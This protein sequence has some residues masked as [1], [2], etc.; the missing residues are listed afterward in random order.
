MLEC[1]N[2]QKTKKGHWS[3]E[4]LRLAIE[5]L[6][7]GGAW[8][9]VSAKYKIP[10][11]SIRDHV[12]GRI[13]GRKM[14]P[15]TVLSTNE[16]QKL[17]DYISLIVSWGHPMTPLQLKNKVVETTQDRLTPFKDG[18]HGRF[19]IKW[20]KLRYPELVLRVSQGLDQR[21]AKGLNPQN[22]ARFYSNL[23]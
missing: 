2:I 15:K 5:A 3:N 11:S 20:F 19:W 9:E 13:I 6:D 14:G 16:E 23:E 21:K 7:E 4:A 1:K 18:I 17:C 8:S 12:I 10:R 22:I